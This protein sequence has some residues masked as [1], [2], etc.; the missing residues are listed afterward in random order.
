MEIQERGFAAV[1]IS[2][3][4]QAMLADKQSGRE[5]IMGSGVG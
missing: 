2:S 4:W 5:R 1:R 3:I